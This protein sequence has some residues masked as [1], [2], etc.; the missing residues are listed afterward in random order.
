MKKKFSLAKRLNIMRAAVMG[1]NDGI[2]SIAGIVI[3]VAGATTNQFSIFIAG[4]SG[5][6]AGTVSMAMGEYVSVNTQ[7]DS[8]KI[9]IKTEKDNLENKYEEVFSFVEQKYLD[10]GIDPKLARQATTEMMENDPLTTIIREKYG[11]NVNEFTSPYDAAISSMIAFPLGSILPMVAISVFPNNIKIIATFI[12][13][14]IALAITG[15][16][17]AKL[18][19]SN[20]KH[21]ML[22]NI[23]SGI[24]TMA[25]TYFIGH[26]IGKF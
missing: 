18:G 14:L 6:L 25:V 8:E 20:R 16:S 15:Y 19:N 22:R 23:I 4:I 21:G 11:F 7:K 13:V 12:A 1:A 10:E 3:G 5:I 26:L 24:I 2:I 17:A 9:A